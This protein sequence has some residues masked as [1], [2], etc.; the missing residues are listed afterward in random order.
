MRS[1]EY[2]QRMWLFLLRQDARFARVGVR[3][4]A[5]R[6]TTQ[7]KSIVAPDG[8]I[9]SLTT[10][11]KRIRTVHLTLESIANGTLL[12]SRVILWLDEASAFENRPPELRRLEARGLEIKLTANYG[13]HKKYYPFLDSNDAFESPLVTA[14]DDVLYPRNWLSGLVKSFEGDCTVIHC[15]HAHKIKMVDGTIA[16]YCS[17]GRSG[18]VNPCFLN[19][20]VGNSGCI[21]PPAFLRALKDAGKGFEQ[22]CPTADDVWLHANGIRA[23]FMTRQIQEHPLD[24]PALPDTQDTGLFVSNVQ[25][26]QNDIQ[27]KKTYR[28]TDIDT[29]L[30]CLGSS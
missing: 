20:S 19:F 9:V 16:P 18:S 2:L 28:P 13:P 15:Y 3:W 5:H 22:Q 11:G 4:F 24:F 7:T 27:I 14:D 30:S 17:W 6:N 8:P 1:G 21:Y 23:K 25:L 26:G 29:L 12:P 10:Y